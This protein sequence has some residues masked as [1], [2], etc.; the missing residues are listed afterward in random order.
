VKEETKRLG[1]QEVDLQDWGKG[2][3][4]K[5]EWRVDCGMDQP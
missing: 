1:W 5:V 4:S 2:D 3:P